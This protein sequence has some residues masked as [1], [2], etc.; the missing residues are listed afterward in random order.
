MGISRQESWDGLP[1]PTPG[2]LPYPG[3]KPTFLLFLVL[4][5]RFFAMNE[6]TNTI[7]PIKLHVEE[8]YRDIYEEKFNLFKV[9]ELFFHIARISEMPKYYKSKY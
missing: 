7:L 3:I 2:D 8:T 5:G 9:Y 6:I 1:F 4:A